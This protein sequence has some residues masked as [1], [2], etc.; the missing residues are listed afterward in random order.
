MAR[1]VATKK[2]KIFMGWNSGKCYHGDLMERSAA[3]LL[4]LTGNW[5][6]KGT[7][8]RSW[9]IAG[10]DGMSFMSA[11]GRLGQDAARELHQ[12]MLGL[13]RLLWQTDPTMTDEMAM[14]MGARLPLGAAIGGMG[15][16]TPPAFSVP[17]SGLVGGPPGGSRR[18]SGGRVRSSKGV[19]ATRSTRRTLA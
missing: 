10:F 12:G 6:K 8:T 9:A 15:R 1:K 11:K 19:R 13:R 2:T 17:C 3:L 18:A 7:G 14:E 4:G 16:M 5:G